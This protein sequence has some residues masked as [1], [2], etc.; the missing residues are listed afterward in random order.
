M[1]A[2]VRTRFVEVLT[3]RSAGKM[4]NSQQESRYQTL[5]YERRLLTESVSVGVNSSIVRMLLGISLAGGVGP[6]NRNQVEGIYIDIEVI[7]T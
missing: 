1:E 6:W 7:C 2:R 4:D 5:S 3:N